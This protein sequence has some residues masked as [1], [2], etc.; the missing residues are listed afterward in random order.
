MSRRQMKHAFPLAALLASSLACA[1]W[2]RAESDKAPTP[3]ALLP[4]MFDL[5][6]AYRRMGFFAH[7]PP[8]AFVG[9]VRYLAGPNPDSTLALFAASIANN[10]L[11]FRRTGSGF[12]ASYRVEVRFD[13]AGSSQAI[14]STEAVRVAGFLE[15]QRAD[16]SVIFQKSVY[17]PPGKGRVEVTFR[18]LNTN[19]YGRDSA[20][21]DVPR[22]GPG[23]SLSSIIPVYEGKGRDTRAGPPEFLLNPRGTV[24]F[25]TDTLRLYLE[26]YGFDPDTDVQ[27]RALDDAGKEVWRTSGQLRG[28]QALSTTVVRAQPGELPVGGLRI[29]AALPSG[30]TVRAPALVSF[31]DHWVVANLDEVIRV[32]RY[33]GYEER[34]RA[35]KAAPEAQRW[36]LWRQF[37][38]DT[39]P[40]P[41]TPENEA[42]VDYFSRVQQANLRFREGADSGWLT[43]RGEVFINLGAPD[44]VFDQ[45][46]GFQGS[47][48]AIR[49]SYTTH[50][51]VLDFVDES[52]FGRYRLSPSSRA[53]YQI[54]LARVRQ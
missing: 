28:T 4:G 8:V 53:D 18:D 45:S 13:V 24:P 32:L 19:G 39:D 25:G 31:S 54:V 2:Q 23:P 34:L 29:E 12:D 17:L 6:V 36:T 30:D 42:L 49:W 11:S 44:E 46:S 51:L 1:N 26:A 40:N 16:E 10:T 20:A 9:T 33:F 52:G 14:S 22:F 27:V 41:L 37:W 35:M 21:L 43:D 5:S 50:R 38:R 47:R 7:G 3:D 48:R 15:T